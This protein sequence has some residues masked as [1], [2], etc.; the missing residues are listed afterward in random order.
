MDYYHT[1]YHDPT[2]GKFVSKVPAGFVGRDINNPI[3]I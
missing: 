2:I 1:K 3:N